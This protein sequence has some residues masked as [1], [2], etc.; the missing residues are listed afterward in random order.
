MPKELDTSPKVMHID[1]AMTTTN[2]TTTISAPFVAAD[3]AS[4]DA[5]DLANTIWESYYSLHGMK[6]RHMS[7]WGEKREDLIE[8]AVFYANWAHEDY[9]REQAQEREAKERKMREA[10]RKA[11]ATRNFNKGFNT[12]A[13][14]F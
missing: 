6:P 13:N 1:V 10:N 9:E 2:N 5:D 11:L 14:A 12:L 7:L 8:D 3:F 4:H